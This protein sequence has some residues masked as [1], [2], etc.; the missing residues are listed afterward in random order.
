MSRVLLLTVVAAIAAVPASA[1]VD[2]DNGFPAGECTFW[3]YAKRPA[4]VDLTVLRTLN[5]RIDQNGGIQTVQPISAWD[6]W[7]WAKNAKKGGF[8]VGTRPAVG[9]IAV[10]PRNTD[11][12][13]PIGHVAYVEKLL[14]GGSFA[15]SEEN[16]AGH[17]SPTR[18][19]VSANRSL[20]F[21]YRRADE[22]KP[23]GKGSVR[24]ISARWAP[25]GRRRRRA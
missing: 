18:R 19:V 20:R 2:K 8:A 11:G 12:A 15:V 1:Y 16:W 9:A 17:R 25:T 4:I 23:A 10:W 14:G 5:V 13:G 22:P 24:R 3:A 21:V 7:L 6:G